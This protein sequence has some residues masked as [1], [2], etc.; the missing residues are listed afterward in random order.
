LLGSI[1]SFRVT[2]G[3][4]IGRGKAEEFSAVSVINAIQRKFSAV[5]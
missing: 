2:D 3:E 5:H 4:P 1:E